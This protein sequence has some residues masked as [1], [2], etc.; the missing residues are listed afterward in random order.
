M[1]ISSDNNL[2]D[3]SWYLECLEQKKIMGNQ[4]AGIRWRTFN[5]QNLNYQSLPTTETEAIIIIDHISNIVIV[6][7]YKK[8]LEFGT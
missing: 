3:I 5:L 6:K 7:L 8:G 4:R 2:P 1:V